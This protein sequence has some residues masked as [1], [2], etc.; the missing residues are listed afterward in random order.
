MLNRITEKLDKEGIQDYE[1]SSRIP[2]DVV[3]INSDLGNLK[4]YL[5]LDYEYN[6]FDIDNFVRNTFGNQIRTSVK[7]DRDIFVISLSTRINEIQYYKLIKFII[8]LTEFI[9]IIDN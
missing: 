2:K 3:S 9:T 1:I 7:Q 8:E 6:Q 5:P 4:I